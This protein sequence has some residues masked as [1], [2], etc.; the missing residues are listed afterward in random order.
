MYQLASAGGTG[1]N[2]HGGG[3]GWYTP[4]A[5]TQEE[6]FVARP[7][8][9]GMLVF[10]QA[11]AGQLVE[12]KLDQREQAPLLTAYGIR[13]DAGGMKVAA[14]HKNATRSVSLTIDAGQR[15]QSVRSLR[16]HAPRV[17][18]TTDATF[19]GAPVGAGGAWSASR[20]EVLTVGNGAAVLDLPAASAALITFERE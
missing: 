12:S 5:G 15:A 7:I 11:G 18:D 20:E 1:I 4:I 14:F 6:G 10:A 16:P 13:N 9:Y 19:G 3:Y 17:D 2:F 8:Y